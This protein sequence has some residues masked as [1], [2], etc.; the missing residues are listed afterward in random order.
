MFPN[1]SS[2][3]NNRATISPLFIALI[4]AFL[5]GISTPVNKYLLDEIPAI[6]L[7]GHLYLGAAMILTPVFL[8]ESRSLQFLLDSSSRNN[9]LYLVGAV[10]FGGVLGPILLL[11]G[12]S[13]TLAGSVSLLL[14]LETVSTAVIGVIFF[15]EHL[16]KLGWIANVGVFISGVILSFEGEFE[17]FLGAILVMGACLCWGLDNCFT[18]K[19]DAI[20]P[21]QSTFIKGLTAGIVNTII[22]VILL[23]HIPQLFFLLVAVLIGAFSYGIS[24]VFYITAAQQLGAT[25]SQMIFASSPFWGLGFSILLLEEVLALN[26]IIAAIL[27]IFSLSLLFR[28]LHEHEHSHKSLFHTHPHDHSDPHHLHDHPT[29]DLTDVGAQRHEHL[30]ITHIHH[31]WPDL[32]HQHE[33]TE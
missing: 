1:L 7:A 19:I 5:F 17:G 2:A 25:R 33:H 11:S 29:H 18:A 8:K 22:G 27:L 15:K 13:L 26:Q 23:P 28:D 14:N 32:H 30:P 4:A 24:I 10:V 20:S 6:Q 3:I 9:L 31:H 21:I 12:L 16:S